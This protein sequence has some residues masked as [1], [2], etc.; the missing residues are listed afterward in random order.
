MKT[1]IRAWVRVT[2]LHLAIFSYYK[3]FKKNK[4][5][6]KI[7][8]NAQLMLKIFPFPKTGTYNQLYITQ[9]RKVYFVIFITR[10]LS[11]TF[12][13]TIKYHI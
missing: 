9:Q 11:V 1:V 8:T 6:R 7:Q 5:F 13:H 10:R 3:A 4:A 2:N 12:W